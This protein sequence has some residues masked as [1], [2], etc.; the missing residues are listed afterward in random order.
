MSNRILLTARLNRVQQL[1]EGGR[2]KRVL[3]APLH[4]TLAMAY[5]Y[6]VY[7]LHKTGWRVQVRTFFGKPLTVKLPAGTDIYLCGGK[8]H[9]SEIRL[10]RL[11]I[12][13]M[14]PGD[15]VL[16]IG[17]HLGFFSLLAQ[18]CVQPNGRVL[19]VEAT[20]STF[21]LLK[22]NTS[23]SAI[24]IVHC[25]LT[26][27]IGNVEIHEFP[28]LYSEFNTLTNQQYEGEEWHDKVEAVTWEVPGN[29]GD[30]L[31]KESKLM[32]QWIK[33]DVEGAEALV[34]EGLNG[35]LSAHSPTLIMEFA[36]GERNQQAHLIAEMQLKKLGFTP[37][38]ILAS[39]A[40]K[41]LGRATPEYLS[42]LGLESDNIV[43]RKV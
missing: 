40:L 36:T 9:D 17:A 28:L 18:T 3:A 25:A 21:E 33:I 6:L 11:F 42:E 38:Q 5:R 30:A 34:I 2:L 31:L 41:K 37:H 29:T 19:A 7:P 43:Y 26:N 20:P 24:E 14:Q 22:K 39:G 23:D 8:T 15:Q 35:Y 13:S 1:A 4:Y 16:D 10:A 12:H 27:Q 32:P